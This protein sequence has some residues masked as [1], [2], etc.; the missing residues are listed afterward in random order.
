MLEDGRT[1][2]HPEDFFHVLTF[3]WLSTD[4]EGTSFSWVGSS[5]S[6][7]RERWIYSRLALRETALRHPGL[8]NSVFFGFLVTTVA[9]PALFG[10]LTWTYHF[11][12]GIACSQSWGRPEYLEEAPFWREWQEL[13]CCQMEKC[14]LRVTPGPLSAGQG[15]QR[16]GSHSSSEEVAPSHRR[17]RWPWRREPVGWS[18]ITFQEL[19]IRFSPCR[20]RHL[21]MSSWWWLVT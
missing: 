3:N 4:V 13:L 6:R 18:S 14:T 17:L 9:E 21:K 12:L 11:M 16:R 19:A 10:L 5:V 2:F 1:C 15:T 7:Q 20:I 8:W